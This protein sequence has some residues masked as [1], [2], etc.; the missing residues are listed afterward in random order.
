RGSACPNAHITRIKQDLDKQIAEHK[1]FTIE[2]M[3][4][5]QQD[6][7]SLRAEHDAPLFK[8]WTA[9]D[10]NAEKARAAIEGWDH[11]LTANT[12]PGAMYVRW[13]T[14]ESGAKAAAAKPGA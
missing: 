6:A 10:A 14:S 9:K 5:I 8:G 2:D 1:K 4:R 12:V 13:T 3:E 7:Y 11:V